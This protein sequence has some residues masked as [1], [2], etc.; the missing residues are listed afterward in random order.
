MT[1]H[2]SQPTAQRRI[3]ALDPGGRRTGV[4]LSDELGLFA[5][6]REAIVSS[7]AVGIAAAVARLVRDE[8]VGEVVVGL[9]VSLSGEASGQTGDAEA[10]VQLLRERLAVPVVTWDERLSSVQASRPLRGATK[11]EEIA[12]DR[13]GRNSRKSG[14]LDS[15]SAAIVLQAVLDARRGGGR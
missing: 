8:D 15:R 7:T 5:H 13:K 1:H 12:P 3:L 14:A 4:A 6:P 11:G 9:P 10:L 2:Q